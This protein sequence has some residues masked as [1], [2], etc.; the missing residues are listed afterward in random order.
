M[1]SGLNQHAHVFSRPQTK[2]PTDKNGP[3]PSV[4]NWAHRQR[5]PGRNARARRV[6]PGP[7][8]V[9]TLAQPL[10]G[11]SLI[12]R[13]SRRSPARPSGV[14]AADPD[15]WV[16][17]AKRNLA[18]GESA[19]HLRRTSS[20]GTGGLACGYSKLSYLSNSRESF[21]S[22]CHSLNL[23]LVVFPAPRVL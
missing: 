12:G 1:L 21:I 18:F 8:P 15:P 2:R 7:P 16:R 6:P 14:T 9:T 13:T 10:A 4:R 5:R 23:T 11:Q 22:A 17:R 3:T 19:P 20:C